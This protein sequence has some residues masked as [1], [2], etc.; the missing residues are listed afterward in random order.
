[1]LDYY[2]TLH[3]LYIGIMATLFIDCYT[4]FIK[5]I[6]NID[7][8]NYRYL[9]RWALSL[10]KGQYRHDLIFTSP[11]IPYEITIGWLLHYLIGIVLVAFF[12]M[13]IGAN[14]LVMPQFSSAFL[15][16]ICSTLLPL[17]I[18]QPL[19]GLGIAGL[20][21]SHSKRVWL[22][23]LVIHSLFGLAIYLS[24]LLFNYI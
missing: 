4:W 18:L 3:I 11:K 12:V 22:K 15:F 8:L 16:G 23:S 14:W 5:T 9:G 1:M 19:F 2:I 10:F 21:Q 13:I 24:A 7:S 20:K 6:F 17:L